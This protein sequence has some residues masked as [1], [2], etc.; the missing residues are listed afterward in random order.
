MLHD[1]QQ[2]TEVGTLLHCIL[3]FDSS[4][5]FIFIMFVFKPPDCSRTTHPLTQPTENAWRLCRDAACVSA[6]LQPDHSCLQQR[7]MKEI[8]GM[9]IWFPDGIPCCDGENC[10][11]IVGRR[12]SRRPCL[13]A[14]D[15]APAAAEMLGDCAHDNAQRV[16]MPMC[17]SLRAGP[18][19]DRSN[20]HLCMLI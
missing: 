4:E 5:H 17:A 15:K 11:K 9:T 7:S 18:R 13:S 2:R 20:S 10:I 12:L 19:M 3:H 6:Y 14:G 1:M 8:A 16:E